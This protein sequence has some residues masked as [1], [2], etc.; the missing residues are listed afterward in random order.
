MAS[1]QAAG[2]AALLVSA[3]K[4]TGVQKQPD[5][6]RQALK[7]SCPAP[8][9]GP[10][11]RYEQG[12]GLIN[13]GA[14]WDL[15]KT[16]IKT[17]DITSSVPVNTVLSGFLATPGIG[18]GIYDREGVTVGQSYT[19]TYT[20]TRTSG[21]GGAV[22]LQP[23][24]GRQRRHVQSR[25]LRSRCR[26]TRRR[27][28]SSRS[29]RPRAAIA[30]GDPQPG[31]PATGRD[32]LPDDERRDRRGPVHG[33]E[34]LLGDE[35]GHD[36]PQPDAELLLPRPRRHAGLQGR[37][38]RPVRR[39]PA[40][41]RRASCASTRTASAIDSNAST[42]CYSPPVAGGAA[43]QPEQPHDVE[44]A[45]RRLGGD[46][47]GTA[48]V[49]RGG[50]PVHADGVD[51]RRD[52][53]AEPGHDRLGD[54]RRADRPLV[55]ADEPVR[56]RSPGRAVGTTLGSA[57]LGHAHRSRNLAQQQYPVRSSR[58]ARRRC[59]R[60]SAARPT[61]QPTSICSSS[62]APPARACWPDRARTATPRSR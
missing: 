46:G 23:V 60:R 62:T 11:R 34:Q 21:G 37:L 10:H 12:N 52:R 55:H 40:R 27:R 59:A 6:L 13:V 56:R 35:D 5:Q 17:V 32:R 43:R 18:Q 61:R 22:D 54:D 14:A 19:R 42:N 9:H 7:S 20:F 24:V 30:L 31:R 58:R 57:R 48:H 28:S 2:A 47:R 51:P 39:R 3:A 41:G 4:Q 44:S 50:H 15:L 33:G 29:T 8:R 53:L 16:N 45:G 26:R 38:H 49:R 1:P 25:R 36:R